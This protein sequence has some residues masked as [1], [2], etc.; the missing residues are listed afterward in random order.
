M[1]KHLQRGLAAL[2]LSLA[3][4]ASLAAPVTV[5]FS[6]TIDSLTSPLVGQS[7][8]GTVNFDDALGSVMGDETL[9]D[10]SGFSFE[11]AGASYGLGDLFSASAVYQNGQF[12]GLDV[13][14]DGFFFLPAWGGAE[15]YFGY[16]FGPDGMGNGSFTAQIEPGNGVPEPTG[17]ALAGLGLIGLAAARR[18]RV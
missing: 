17:L 15:A 9:F 12:A 11:F 4:W 6:V 2:G 16:D 14:A 13:Q 3:N 7:F 5:N 8:T 10:L 1:N 18:R